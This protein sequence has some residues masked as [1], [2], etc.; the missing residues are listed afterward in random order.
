MHLANK[1][2][3]ENRKALIYKG[4]LSTLTGWDWGNGRVNKMKDVQDTAIGLDPST[5]PKKTVQLH[6]HSNTAGGGEKS[7]RDTNN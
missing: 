2:G 4:N 7:P 1:T 5:S 6:E 3:N